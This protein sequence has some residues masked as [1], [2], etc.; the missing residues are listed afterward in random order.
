[1]YSLLYL[2]KS[3]ALPVNIDSE[4]SKI[5]NLSSYLQIVRSKKSELFPSGL[6]KIWSLE[7]TWKNIIFFAPS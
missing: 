3:E 4:T 5:L 2:K 6:V 1:M 7:D